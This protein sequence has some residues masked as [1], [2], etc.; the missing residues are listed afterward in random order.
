[1]NSDY[2]ENY[3]G[4]PV[5]L[6]AVFLPVGIQARWRFPGFKLCLR[7]S[8]A[9]L[10]SSFR[11]HA[12]RRFR[13]HLG[14]LVIVVLILGVGLAALREANDIWDCGIFSIT[15]GALLISILLGVHRTDKRRAFW[16]GFAL[17]GSAYLALSLIP[18]IESRLITNRALAYL[19]SKMPRSL[20]A[21]L[22]YADFDNDGKLDLY[23]AN[24]S[25]P[26]TLFPNNGN[27]TFVDATPAARFSNIFLG[28]SLTG[29]SGTT[30]NFIRIGHSL[31]ALLAAFLGG[32]LPRHLYAKNREPDTR[33][34]NS[35]A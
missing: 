32:L 35:H 27:G 12:L 19:D 14:T 16:L 22:T 1:V 25:H 9:D 29:S 2:S 7:S 8:L 13:F 17:F 20:P 6:L 18:S 34:L 5:V 23:V 24:N 21:G 11:D 15:L 10:L 28:T 4:K 30:E 26:N 31:L 3:A 33:P